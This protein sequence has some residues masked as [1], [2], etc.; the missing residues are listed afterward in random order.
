MAMRFSTHMPGR[1]PTVAV[2]LLAVIVAVCLV[3]L[4]G[5]TMAV[6]AGQNCFGP[7]C[8]DQLACG[9]PAQPQASWGTSGRLVAVPTAVEAPSA[10]EKTATLAQVSPRARLARQPVAPLAPRSPPAA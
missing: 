10:P 4:A 3:D 8:E 5:A 9:Q 2:L 1:M 7:V 6:A